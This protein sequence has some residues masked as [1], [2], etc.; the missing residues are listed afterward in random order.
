MAYYTVYW[1]KDRLEELRK[2]D[3]NGPIKVVFG[4]I[5]S[6]MPSIA[7]IK[8]GDVVFPVS[9]FDRHLYIMARLEVTH[10]ER[11][12]D[13]CVRELGAHYKSLIPEGVVVKTSDTFF[14][15]KDVS[16]KSL[17][18]VPENLTMI[19]PDDK[20][21]CKHQEPFNC[22][23]EWAV[24]GEN[25]SVIQPRLI[26]DE[27]VPLLRFGYPKSK[28]KPLRINSKGVVLAQSI[29]ATRRLSEESAMIFEGVIKTA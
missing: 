26:P 19:I 21:H 24:W 17:Q 3:D 7:S 9:L 23:A 6:R 4:S 13:Y 1:S 20:P 16:Y 2:A 22:C 12:F 29:A 15:A 25:G 11:A 18:S 10:K 8:V 14:C 27:V 5:H 28:E